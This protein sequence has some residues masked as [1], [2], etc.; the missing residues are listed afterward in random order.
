MSSTTLSTCARLE[1]VAA[2]SLSK[3]NR[4]VIAF[5]ALAC[6]L[7]LPPRCD[8]QGTSPIMVDRHMTVGAGAT[9]VAT[10]GEIAARGEDA[11]VPHRLFGEQGVSKRSTN[12]LY[13][14]LKL[15]Y[16]DLPQ[17][18]VIL[19]VN[20]EVFGHGA[21]LRERFNGSISYEIDVPA[22]Y[23]DG[24]GSTSFSL[25]REPSTAEWLAI[26]A[27]GMEVDGVSAGLIAHRAFLDGRMR[28]RDAMRYFASELDTVS[29]VLGTGDYTEEPGHD[30]FGFLQNYNEAAA[31]AGAPQLTAATLRREVIISF[32]NPMLGYAIFGMGRYIWNGETD[33]PVPVLRIAGVRYLPY[34]RYRLTPF[35]TEWAVINE[36]AGRI[37][38]LQ[39]EARFGRSPGATPFG[40]GVRRENLTTVREWRI[41][42]SGDFWRQ[43]PID[44]DSFESVTGAL[45]WGA[46]IRGRA[47]RPL[48]RAWFGDAPITVIV[49][50]ALKTQGFVAGEPL[51]P[52]LVARVGIGIPLRR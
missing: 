43:P 17:E 1:C 50:L 5:V 42:A 51:G 31:F 13:R 26:S 48:S 24:G 34:V 7:G 30:V 20:H 11:F 52:G 12:V 33:V 14:L 15:T 41:D 29:Y 37:P 3:R 28:A 40:F 22:P 38:P 35:G 39:I 45:R 47:E 16:F 36:L 49:D 44:G 2:R 25:D 21:R 23:G 4:V 27:G 9:V 10:F 46:E 32:A 18:N 6:A 19:V 8:A